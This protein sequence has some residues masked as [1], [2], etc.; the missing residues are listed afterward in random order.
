MNAFTF[1][2]DFKLEDERVL[3]RELQSEDV[4]HLLPISLNEPENWEFGL[5][6]ASGKENLT[7]YISN[8]IKAGSM[9]QAFPF[10]IF[11]KSLQA[12]A[13]STRY[14]NLNEAHSRLAIGYSWIGNSFKQTGLNTHVKYLMLSHAFEAFDVERVEFMADLR[15]E[16]SIR[17]ILSLGAIQEGVLRSHAIKPDGTRR[18][19][20]VFSIL[21]KEWLELVKPSL[22]QKINSIR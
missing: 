20:A 22:Y 21:K 17:S 11:D 4:E 14:Y 5:E 3:L 7:A 16:Q 9:N 19:T 15:N 8:A 10:I 6:N 2:S 18:D 12:Y 13:G 1:P